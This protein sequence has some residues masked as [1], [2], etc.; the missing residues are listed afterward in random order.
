VLLADVAGVVLT[1]TLL[2]SISVAI[3][4]VKGDVLSGPAVGDVQ[5]R[6]GRPAL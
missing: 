3:V 1:V 5:R 6:H 2:L 4:A